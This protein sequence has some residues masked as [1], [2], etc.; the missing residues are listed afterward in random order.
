M[1]LTL[2]VQGLHFENHFNKNT[3]TLMGCSVR[4]VFQSLLFSRLFITF[5]QFFQLYL[6]LKY[7]QTTFHVAYRPK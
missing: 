3:A 1:R 7:V 4:F 6:F 2:L 5:S